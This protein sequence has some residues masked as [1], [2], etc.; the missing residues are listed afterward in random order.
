M[1]VQERTYPFRQVLSQ[2][3]ADCFAVQPMLSPAEL[4]E[5]NLVAIFNRYNT[6]DPAT[7]SLA[8]VQARKTQALFGLVVGVQQATA[9]LEDD[10]EVSLKS[11]LRPVVGLGLLLKPTTFNDKLALRLEVLYQTQV[12]KGEYVRMNR[13]ATSLSSNRR[14]DVT[15][16]T[17]RVPL[18]LR[19]TLPKGIV[20]P[21]LQAGGEI[22]TLLDTH[23]AL[24]VETNQALGGVGTATSV[25][26][27][28]MRGFGFGFTGAVGVVVPVG[29]GTFQLEARYNQLDNSSQVVGQLGGTQTVFFLLGYNWGR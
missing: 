1:T 17:L 24:I 20:R 21:Y 13:I 25:R 8:K 15:L 29:P 3:F 11:S 16:N 2:A 18:M 27:I 28:E 22:S 23:K 19:Y 10:G 4:K 14:G 6:C 12:L 5:S 7:A 26:E 9:K